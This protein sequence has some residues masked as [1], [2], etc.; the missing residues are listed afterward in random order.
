MGAFLAQWLAPQAS[1]QPAPYPE[2]YPYSPLVVARG[3][4]SDIRIQ[5]DGNS[6]PKT[7]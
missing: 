4:A 2:S 5:A 1:A 7:T 6:L 3:Q